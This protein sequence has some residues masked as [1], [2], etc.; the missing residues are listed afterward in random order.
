MKKPALALA[1]AIVTLALAG[2]GRTVTP[3]VETVTV[4]VPVIRTE[5]C[6]ARADI[7]AVPAGLPRP[8]P[9]AI[10]TALDLAVAKVLEFQTYAE[11]ANALLRG[12]AAEKE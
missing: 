5:K 3:A 11:K 1:L 9:R 4:K 7:P 2:C 8:R 12:C 6:V 10:A